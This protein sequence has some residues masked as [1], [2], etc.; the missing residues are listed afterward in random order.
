MAMQKKEGEHP[1]IAWKKAT[2]KTTRRSNKVQ[3]KV[4]EVQNYK[5]HV[6]DEDAAD[7]GRYGLL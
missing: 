1:A 4:V 2:K 3:D 5:S 6:L 7:D